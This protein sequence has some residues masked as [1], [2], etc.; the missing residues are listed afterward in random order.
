MFK[1]VI[2]CFI[3]IAILFYVWVEMKHREDS[4]WSLGTFI[5]ENILQEKASNSSAPPL[6]EKKDVISGLKL[7]LR[8]T[9]PSNAPF[10][11]TEHDSISESDLS[12]EKKENRWV[13]TKIEPY[14]S[15]IIRDSSSF[16]EQEDFVIVLFSIE[17]FFCIH[18]TILGHGG[19]RQKTSRKV[20]H[21]MVA[22]TLCET[23]EIKNIDVYD[24]SGKSRYSAPVQVQRT[25]FPEV[26]LNNCSNAVTEE[27]FLAIKSFSLGIES[28]SI[29]GCSIENMNAF[30]LCRWKKL[31]KVLI[32][33]AD[34]LSLI[35]FSFLSQQSIEVLELSTLPETVQMTHTIER[36]P[37]RIEN[38]YIDAFLRPRVEHYKNDLNIQRI[39][40][41][42]SKEASSTFSELVPPRN[43]VQEE[44]FDDKEKRS[45]QE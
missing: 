10:S 3:L 37:K 14:L 9:K 13:H 26:V 32:K 30:M 34:Q 42:E 11:D 31:R 41:R 1:Q 27:V 12:R 8:R 19:S 45:R 22:R 33:E 29:T 44:Y 21:E 18:L 4:T 28:I 17:K 16:Q 2:G 5:K 23:L 36:A 25:S 20:I 7:F 39:I 35:D 24:G 40:S 15:V 38:L 6:Q 43:T